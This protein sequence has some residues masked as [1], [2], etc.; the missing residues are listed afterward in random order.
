MRELLVLCFG[1]LKTGN[2]NLP[3]ESPIHGFR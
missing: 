1:G 2:S 3:K